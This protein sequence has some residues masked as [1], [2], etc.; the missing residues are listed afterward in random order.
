MSLLNTFFQE[1]IDFSLPRWAL[2]LIGI[3]FLSLIF[4]GLMFAKSLLGAG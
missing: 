4:V 2:F 3:G 1:V